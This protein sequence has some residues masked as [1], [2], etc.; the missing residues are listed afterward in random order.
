MFTSR[1]DS[2]LLSLHTQK[3]V[4]RITT[5]HWTNKPYSLAFF[6][7]QDYKRDSLQDGMVALNIKKSRNIPLVFPY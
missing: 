5:L 3:Q 4:V 2:E 6:D 7:Q 1:A